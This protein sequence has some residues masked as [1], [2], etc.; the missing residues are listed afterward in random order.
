[1]YFIPSVD[2]LAEGQ[3]AA[4]ALRA[5]WRMHQLL[6]ESARTRIDHLPAPAPV[7]VSVPV[8]A[9]PVSVPAHTAD[10]PKPVALV[11]LAS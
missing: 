8:A 10:K 1:M 4:D 5:Q 9:A 2:Q 3:A 7:S 11:M 6:D